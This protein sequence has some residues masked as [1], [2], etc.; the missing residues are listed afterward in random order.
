MRASLTL[1]VL[2]STLACEPEIRF[3]EALRPQVDAP[4]PLTYSAAGARYLSLSGTF[5]KLRSGECIDYGRLESDI[6][7]AFLHQR[8]VQAFADARPRDI[9]HP[10]DRLAFWINA[11]NTAVHLGLSAS[12]PEERVAV[13]NGGFRVLRTPIL[14]I[15]GRRLAPDWIHH[16]VLRGD[17][18]HISLA[19]I[20]SEILEYVRAQNTSFNGWFDPRVHFALACGAVSCPR[21]PPQAYRGARLDK[22]LDQSVERFLANSDIGASS[23]AVSSI[24]HW[25]AAD[26]EDEGGPA[27]FL[28]RYLPQAGS[29]TAASLEFD[30]RTLILDPED[31]RCSSPVREMNPPPGDGGQGMGPVNDCSV[32]EQRPC[33][34]TTPI[35]ICQPGMERCLEGVWSE[36]VDSVEATVEVCNGLDDDC[37]GQIDNAPA[38]P[39]SAVC[40][41]LGVC[42]ETLTEC[43][44]GQWSC[45][46]PDGYEESE[47]TC[48]GLD[49]DCD[50]LVDEGVAPPADFGS[51]VGLGECATGEPSCTS[52]GWRCTYPD[53]VQPDME[54][55]CDGLDNDCDATIDE[56]LADCAC[57]NGESRACGSDTGTCTTGQQ[58]CN[59]GVWSGCDGLQPETE[60]CD[61]L[62]NDCNGTTDDGV[63]NECGTCGAAP[64]EIC[65]GQDNDCDGT[66][67]EDSLN[68]CGRCGPV[69]NE[70][71][72][73]ADDDCDGHIDEGVTNACGACGEIGEETC[74]GLDD[75]CDGALDED[76]QAPPGIEC[77]GLGV[78]A[79]H[80]VPGCTG[81][82]GFGCLYP[83]SYEETETQCDFR[84]NDCDGAVDEA[85]LN[86]CLFCGP[87]PAEACNHLDDDCDGQADEGCP[88][89]PNSRP[90][91]D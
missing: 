62:D 77:L 66:L 34:P 15:S 40:P 21:I 53:S 2:C 36:C 33:G 64:M 79:G 43:R 56:D 71:C 37:D 55:L 17:F 50:G 82:G 85:L 86:S 39:N 13:S 38:M 29:I 30:W 60:V 63:L 19:G 14:S 1:L 59:D 41:T 74:N 68:Q 87:D 76:V 45:A 48:D 24:F 10:D 80:G 5:A 90:S 42:S 35:G 51:C 6:E 67:D 7:L 11:Y 83:P 22:Q 47:R 61:G 16:G 12:A 65:D 28:S 54:T 57:V 78:C 3:S 58:R 44:S 9:T 20:D 52:D 4:R 73:G 49:N 32:G 18:E 8:A 25:Y 72:N 70:V 81:A 46:H 69:P 75:D 88:V 84:D 26:F 91:R 31:P 23:S 89:D 27:M